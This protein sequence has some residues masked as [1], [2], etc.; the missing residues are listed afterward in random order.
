MAVLDGKVY[1]LKNGQEVLIRTAEPDD[2][3]ALLEHTR[4]ILATDPYNVTRLEEF[5]FTIE[6]ERKWIREHIENPG[7]IIL[8]AE[9][10]GAIVGMISFENGS[11]KRLA[12]RGSLHISVAPEHR[13]KGTADTL[14]QA[15]IDWAERNPLIEKLSLGV[16]AT[17]K[18]AI[19]LYRK[20]G[21]VEEG[22]RVKEI[23]IAQGRYVD[24]ILMY[25]FVKNPG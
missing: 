17:N 14:L 16:F 23:K 10:A 13:R 8:V 7:W 25:R 4:I 1:S 15:L 20:N 18:P 6:K 19:A 3:W 21:F 24:D 12:H 11:R 5:K 22:R 9:L 2:A